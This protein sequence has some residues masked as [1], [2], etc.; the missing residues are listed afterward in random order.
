MNNTQ[1]FI[2]LL[3]MAGSTYLIRALPF[4]LLTKKIENKYIKSFLYYI[5]YA[6]L[7][8][9]TIPAALFATKSIISAVT[10]LI[11][12]VILALKGKSLTF[13][14]VSACIVVYVTELVMSL[15]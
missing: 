8:A 10:G 2:Y 1:Y 3:I 7:S 5:P 15:I 6:V 11:V 13:V 4:S 14:A 9:M 12:A